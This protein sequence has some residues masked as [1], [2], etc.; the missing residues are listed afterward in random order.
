METT[1]PVTT[2]MENEARAA[3][4]AYLGEPAPRSPAVAFALS[5]LCPG[6]GFAYVG[7]PG[8]AVAF[9]LTSVLLWLG[10][11][12]TWV[13]LG[14]Y[15]DGPLL[16]FAA[17]WSVWVLLG[18]IDASRVARDV[19][20]RYT[21]SDANHPLAY[22]AIA[23]FAF[24]FP[25]AGLTTWTLE[26]VWQRVEVRGDAMYPTLVE[27]DV[28]WVERQ[29]YRSRLPQRGDVVAYRSEGDEAV[30]FGRVIGLPG[31]EVVVAE[32]AAYVNDAPMPQRHADPELL[33]RI[34]SLSGERDATLVLTERTGDR[35]Y[36][37]ASSSQMNWGPPWSGGGED[38][39]V[40]LHDARHHLG[41]SRTVGSIPLDALIG[42]PR[43]IAEH[44]GS[45]GADARL[46]AALRVQPA[47]VP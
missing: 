10:F 4:R 22:V 40:L 12:A 45:A 28:V 32:H 21:L 29:A 6:L 16:G 20:D 5:A 1:R 37:V 17:G 7:R 8:T 47:V 11:V 35:V 15:P 39:V 42:R 9:G 26:H 33:E 46:R 34:E 13:A 18:A 27:G 14:F 2:G 36:A 38:G 41:D 19:R 31:D 23:L 24:V 25:A 30:R 44:A 3:E 43:F